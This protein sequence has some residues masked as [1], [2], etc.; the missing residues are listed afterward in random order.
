MKKLCC[1]ILALLLMVWASLPAM[2]AGDGNMDGGSGGM[3]TGSSTCYW[4][5]GDDGVRVT[6]VTKEGVQASAPI[7]YTNINTSNVGYSFGKVSKISYV[8]GT[9]LNLVTGNYSSKAPESQMPR[10]ISTS[11]NKASIEK[12]K[13]YW[14]TDIAASMVSN[15]TGIDYDA[16]V[17]GD[18]KLL[19]E[20]IAYFHFNG[21]FFAM[22]ATEAAKYNQLTNGALRASMV[23]LTSKNLPLAMYLQVADLGFPAF[24][25]SSPVPQTDDTIISS[26]GIGIVSFKEEVKEET[27]DA[28]YEYRT[29]TDVI[30][31][32]TLAN[33]GSDDVTPDDNCQVE[34]N[35][36]G[37]TYRKEFICPSGGRQLVWVKWHTPSAPQ[38]VNIM[39]GGVGFGMSTTITANI[40]KLTESTPPDPQYG[41]T[42]KSF[43]LA[44]TPDYGSSTSASWSVWSAEW[45]P[46]ETKDDIGYWEFCQD[47]YTVSLD[48]DFT[49]SPDDRVQTATRNGGVWRMK[50]G[51]GINADCETSVHTSG[52]PSFSTDYTQAQTEIATF[53]DFGFKTYNRFLEPEGGGTSTD[54][55]FKVNECSYYGCRVHFTPLWYP[56]NTDYVVALSVFDV[57]TPVGMLYTTA[58]DCVSISGSVYDDWYIR[59]TK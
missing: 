22:T 47:T 8:G 19:M 10:I 3:G 50:S 5:G 42:N 48:V 26:L 34:F 40:V 54:W 23:S 24:T 1:Y 18:Y 43:K 52:G 39:V 37:Q 33:N 30:T 31:S 7:D 59:L 35:I 49:V 32:I 36:L 56:D 12:I 11:A 38:R 57:W 6:V 4:N 13:A 15:D 14:C 9:Q 45:V 27:S 58:S 51:Y 41:D 28:N 2:A 29:D 53:S 46:P 17:N 16:L 55:R 44:D 20:P 21:L 25:Y